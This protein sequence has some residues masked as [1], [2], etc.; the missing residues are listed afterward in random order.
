[1]SVKPAAFSGHN[2]SLLQIV[3]LGPKWTITCGSC[4]NTFQKRLPMVNYPGVACPAC[5]QVNVIS[6]VVE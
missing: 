2:F 4:R 1:V 6:V 3:G 5:G